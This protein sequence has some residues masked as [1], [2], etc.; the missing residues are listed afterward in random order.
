MAR[1]LAIDWDGVEARFALGSVQKDRLIVWK[2][3]S[4]PIVDAA[5]AI[6]EADEEADDEDEDAGFVPSS[7]DGEN[8]AAED[9]EDDDSPIEIVETAGVKKAPVFDEDDE[10]EED[11]D[12][13]VVS[14][15]RRKKG[16]SFKTSPLATTLKNL[17]RE[18][19]VGSAT[20][21]YSAERGDLDVLYTT[22]P[23]A[24]DAETPELVLNQALREWA[25]FD[26]KTQPLDYLPL[27][28]PSRVGT[29]SVVAVSIARDKQ[30]RV[31][32]TLIGA[33]RAPSKIELRE[34]SLAEF[35]RA[36]FCKLTFA[37]PTLLIQALCD[38]VNLTLCDAEKNV[39]YFRS[40]K[41]ATDLSAPALAR[42][43]REEIARTLAVGIADLPEDAAVRKALFFSDASSLS[44]ASSGVDYDDSDA[45]E[46]ASIT[47]IGEDEEDAASVVVGSLQLGEHLARELEGEEIELEFANPFRVPGVQ[48]KTLEPEN[49]GRFAS[50]LGMLLAERPQNRPAIDL[51]HP[52]EKPK[53]PKY[54]AIV[55]AFLVL[56]GAGFGAAWKWNKT[57]LDR[58]RA[59]VGEL[60]KKA[61]TEY[62]LALRKQPLANVLMYANNWRDR[63]GVVVLDEL[64]DI[65]LRIP[66]APDLVVT[67]LGYLANQN[68]R[69]TFIIQA[70]IKSTTVYQTFR[71]SLIA[72]RSHSV[73]GRGPVPNR[74]G[75]GYP[76]MF[77]ARIV[78]QRRAPQ[79]FVAKLPPELRQISNKMPEYFAE[80]ELEIQR[81]QE[82]AAAK[83]AA[84]RAEALR[85]Q[86][87]EAQKQAEAARQAQEAAAQAA[88]AQQPTEA[89]PAPEA[90]SEAAP[91]PAPETPTE[92]A[93]APAPE[94]PAAPAEPAP[95]PEQ[96]AAPAEP[97]PAPEQ[98][99]A[100]AEPAPA[101]EQPAAPAEPAPAPEQP[102]AP[103]EPAPAP[104]QPAAPAEP[105]PAP[106]QPAE[107]AQAPAQAAQQ[108]TLEQQAQ[109]GFQLMQRRSWLNGQLQIAQ[110][111]LRQGQM[112]Q[113]QYQQTFAQY[114]TATKNVMTRWA[115][116]P[117]AARAKAQ[118]LW[119][120]Q[121]KKAQ[122]QNAQNNQNANQNAQPAASAPAA[123]QPA[124]PAPAA[125]QPATPAPA[126]EQPQAEG[127]PSAALE[128]SQTVGTEA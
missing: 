12:P 91:A 36:D 31:R 56:V 98:P 43:I 28:T 32:E 102:A 19:R 88:Q 25:T 69:P 77:D 112:N 66:S 110:N 67:R 82:A 41:V 39:L 1:I 72:D 16:E 24:T 18:N 53:P 55:V 15:T 29:R 107:S 50:L 44:A 100:P 104:E 5:A 71:Q 101:P 87:E 73:I 10:E 83:A 60:Q 33:T 30:R 61:Q 93:P 84:E 94:Q 34:P 117:E 76:Y 47:E 13:R 37:E 120:E 96:P 63:Q 75:G 128:R 99:A 46:H 78:C 97:A 20:V 62:Q 124:A 114:Q 74:N 48:L 57:E 26:A 2:A 118:E 35:L 59:A 21:V 111:K 42:R 106:E 68:G 38:E 22:V 127:A 45:D 92:A 85:R 4:A 89:A 6:A 113:A 108:P 122:A 80:R 103:A 81:E 3:G 126:A 123:E 23:L 86:Q 52:R 14:T 40:F 9:D 90:P 8:V 11:D 125:E 79:T 49:P 51:L 65:A 70:K 27:G 95:A 121:L 115:A 105:A 54:W 17:L 119:Q 109:F 116:L 7:V 58:E 64:R